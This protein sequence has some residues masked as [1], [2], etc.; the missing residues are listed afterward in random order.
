MA[1]IEVGSDGGWEAVSSSTFNEL[2]GEIAKFG[3]HPAYRYKTTM[4]VSRETRQFPKVLQP[5]SSNLA[6]F[7]YSTKKYKH[8]TTPWDKD[9]NFFCL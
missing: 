3:L 2:G 4:E 9:K 8:T 6:S 5:S 1:S 7:F